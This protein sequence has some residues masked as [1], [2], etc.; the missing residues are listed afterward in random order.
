MTPVK[1]GFF[2]LDK[3]WRLNGSQ[4]SDTLSKEMV[5]LSGLLPS[6]RQA[7]QVFQRIGH[8]DI[9]CSNL[10][11]R[12]QEKGAQM[13]QCLEHQRAAV[14]PERIILSGTAEDH[15]QCKGL[16]IDGGM[17]NIRDEGWKEFKVGTVSDIVLHPEVDPRTGEEVDQPATINTHYSAVLGNVSDFAPA[18]WALAVTHQVP[19][20]ARSCL[21]ADGAE[22]IWGLAADYFPDSV[23]I[24][25]WYHADEHLAK[26]AHALQ[27]DDEQA[28][29]R[30]R[31]KMHDP[32]FAGKVWRI[33][34]PLDQAQLSEHARY[35][36]RHQ[37]R[38]QYQEFR[39]EGYPIGSGTVE[40]GIKQ[41]KAR[42]TGP[43]MRWER[44]GADRMLVIR[45]AVLGETFNDLWDAAQN[46]PPL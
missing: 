34:Q 17:V 14:A 39:E 9:P 6:F 10:W 15:D 44:V 23:Q 30:W 31:K 28:A 46:S 4:Y 5:W 36:H 2:P 18:M 29:A 21:T 26:A 32:L 41:Y 3:R 43:G 25:D 1:L 11:Q 42:L 40:S 13:K 35:F 16:S 24:V 27:P 38:M 33:T 20:A 12:T 19:Q 45:S 7:Q 22:W 8:R 37:R